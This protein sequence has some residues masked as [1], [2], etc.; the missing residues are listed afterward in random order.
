MEI[1]ERSDPSEYTI[2]YNNLESITKWIVKYDANRTWEI[3]KSWK[4]ETIN[5]YKRKNGDYV[6]MKGGSLKDLLNESI[7][8][9]SSRARLYY[10]STKK[11]TIT[12]LIK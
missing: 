12:D 8:W 3:R 1:I 5:C 2:F 4:D 6:Y 7:V 10:V 9:F 11:G